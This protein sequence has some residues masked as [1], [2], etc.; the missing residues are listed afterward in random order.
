MAINRTANLKKI[1]QEVTHC[2]VS[3]HLRISTEQSEWYGL[4][5]Q[6]T[7]SDSV[8]RRVV[9]VVGA[10]A[11]KS[12]GLPLATE[13]L[14][15]LI[16]ESS[17]PRIVLDAEL[18][19]LSKVYRLDRNTFEVQLRAL[20]TSSYEA[21]KL[22]NNLQKMYGHRFMP[23]LGY[24][25][26]AH[27]LKHRFLDAIIN[28]NFDELLDQSIDDELNP[29]EYYH[30]LSDGDC[31]DEIDLRQIDP[32]IPFYIK[33]HGTAS[34][35]FSLRFTREDY[36]GLSLPIQNMMRYL[37]TDKPVV[38]L[39]V[40]FGMQSLEI[41]HILE[42]AKP[43]SMMFHINKI[44]PVAKNTF[45]RFSRNELLDIK[46]LD[47]VSGAL[48][49][50]WENVSSSFRNQY[51]PR[52][53]DRHILVAQTFSREI[54]KH[55]VEKYLR[56]RT[57]IE[58]GL[59][60][61]KGKG[62][63]TMSQLSIDR[64]GKY[65]DH[66]KAIRADSN[67]YEICNQIGLKDIGYAR[68]AM[69]LMKDDK[70]LSKILNE[71]E[72]NTETDFLYARVQDN[73]DADSR[74]Q[75]SKDIFRKTLLELYEGQEVELRYYSHNPY[76]K[77]FRFPKP[78]PTYTTFKFYTD[79]IL[80]QNWEYLFVVAETGQWLTEEH[81]VRRIEMKK[82]KSPRIKMCLVVAD[83]SWAKKL[84]RIYGETTVE[85]RELPWWEH[86]RH[87]TIP[88]NANRTPL[89][90]IYFSR[91]LRT[92]DITPV[93][94]D[95]LNDSLIVL[96]LFSAYWL[97]SSL[98]KEYRNLGKW[99]SSSDVKDFTKLFDHKKRSKGK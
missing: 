51:R 74:N 8:E 22:R 87:M 23:V 49:V 75:L 79:Q 59:S 64:S 13:V 88:V 80:E 32:E 81:I 25:I 18:D 10:G 53:I 92:T 43:G 15:F 85:I 27:M 40:G 63:V 76:T 9:A 14:Q 39:T 72:F 35:K 5:K 86:N 61:A 57:I 77:I 96:E 12:V 60:I 11:S 62:L 70:Q 6:G 44:N 7:L 21:E 73:L 52:G 30:I 42:D 58:L 71:K 50:V 48:K 28:F 95:N 16:E 68:E 66:Y 97:K 99:I 3:N 89:A 69:R 98:S 94:L 34:R 20:S 17:M 46:S 2:L 84:H 47:S 54:R 24:E 93:L 90:S 65:F 83:M 91:R 36:Y 55:N 29:G 82:V 41:N 78:I 45:K 38:L 56:G 33:A 67:F 1:I 19:R 37:L 31:P 4:V 26:L